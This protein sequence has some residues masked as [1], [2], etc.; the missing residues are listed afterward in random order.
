MPEQLFRMGTIFPNYKEE[1]C[2]CDSIVW[3]CSIIVSEVR[4]EPCIRIMLTD[5]RHLPWFTWEKSS[6]QSLWILFIHFV[7]SR[8][9][10]ILF[11]IVRSSW[12]ALQSV[13]VASRVV[14]DV[15]CITGQEPETC[16]WLLVCHTTKPHW[17]LNWNLVLYLLGLL[18]RDVSATTGGWWASIQ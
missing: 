1:F 12:S 2:I 8:N 13:S 3:G 9:G 11:W 4:M 7:E 18:G 14:S 17:A 15:S 5:P 6:E 10:V 16:A